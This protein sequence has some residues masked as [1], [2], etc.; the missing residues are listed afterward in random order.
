MALARDLGITIARRR[1]A[2]SEPGGLS[3]LQSERRAL[4]GTLVRVATVA[5]QAIPGAQGAGLT[6]LEDDRQQTVVATA[7]FVRAV[8]EVQY[9]LGEGP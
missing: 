4:E 6:L 1:D 9:G 5:V 2:G 7:A 3:G 8:D